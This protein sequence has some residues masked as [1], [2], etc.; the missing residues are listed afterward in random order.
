MAIFLLWLDNI[1]CP[2]C[3]TVTLHFFDTSFQNN[4]VGYSAIAAI[5]T[6]YPVLKRTETVLNLF[7]FFFNFYAGLVVDGD[8]ALSKFLF[9][10]CSVF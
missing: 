7:H 10:S 2:E 6:E 1:E 4:N 3:I 9:L 8:L 5:L